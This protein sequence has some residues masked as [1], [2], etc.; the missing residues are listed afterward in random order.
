M[1][2]TRTRDK[3]LIQIFRLLTEGIMTIDILKRKT[4]FSRSEVRELLTLG[5]NYGYIRKIRIPT[6][7]RKPGKRMTLE[8]DLKTGRPLYYYYLSSEGKWIMRLDPEVQSIWDQ[9]MKEYERLNLEKY[10]LFDSYMN[11]EHGINQH[12]KLRKYKKPY[13]FMDEELQRT[14]LNPFIYVD[15][16]EVKEVVELYD[17]LIET[18]KE[19]IKS[20]HIANYYLTL[21][22]GV[23]RLR[24]I[25]LCHQI[26]MDKLKKLPE[27]Q[28]YIKRVS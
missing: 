11:L 21:A 26:L 1:K 10:T 16:Y 15:K 27:V 13:Y 20:E 12:P 18:I 24:I 14:I 25:L 19:N 23:E 4:D 17:E 22:D 7:K 6:I 3:K 8:P 5:Q 28:E 2:K 9:F